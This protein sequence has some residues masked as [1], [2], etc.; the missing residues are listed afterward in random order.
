MGIENITVGEFVEQVSSKEPVP[1]GGAVGAV[2]AALA[3]GLTEMVANLT[4][5][6][7]KYKEWEGE[8]ER[9]VSEMEKTKE[10][11]YL[12]AK[13]DMDAFN[14]FMEAMKL[15]KNTEEE[16]KIRQEKM[17]GALKGAID[18]P[19]ELARKARDIIKQTEIV[20]EFGNKNAVSDALSAAE[21]CK[22]AF[23]IAK[24][25]VYINLKYLKDEKLKEYY[26]QETDELEK[27]V[28]GSYNR[29]KEMIK[30]NGW[31]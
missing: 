17:Q 14:A 18:V 26:E 12:I 16:K 19:Y 13:K 4:I 8:M 25:N 7:K 22:A 5:G 30:E 6:K 23:E 1:G 24:A 3:A 31:L 15:P 20:T 28:Y 27:Q 11:L 9:V 29:I 2:V 21:L 10:E